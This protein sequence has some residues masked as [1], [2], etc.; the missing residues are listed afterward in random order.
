[1]PGKTSDD[2][3]SIEDVGKRVDKTGRPI[4]YLLCSRELKGF[5]FNTRSWGTSSLSTSLFLRPIFFFFLS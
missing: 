3:L 5:V 2:D 1:M 4:G